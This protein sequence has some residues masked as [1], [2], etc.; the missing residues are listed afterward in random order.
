MKFNIYYRIIVTFVYQ[1]VM[2]L[3]NEQSMEAQNTKGVET[4]K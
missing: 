3:G 2:F 4:G 1:Y